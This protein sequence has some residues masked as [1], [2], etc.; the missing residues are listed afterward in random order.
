MLRLRGTEQLRA[1]RTSPPVT[2]N[3]P[4]STHSS[5]GKVRVFLHP[6]TFIIYRLISVFVDFRLVYLFGDHPFPPFVCVCPFHEAPFIFA[7]LPWCS[8][9]SVLGLYRCYCCVFSAVFTI[10][11]LDHVLIEQ[12]AFARDRI[13]HH[14]SV[15]D[16]LFSICEEKQIAEVVGLCGRSVRSTCLRSGRS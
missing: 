12:G 10:R 13:S 6:S 16:G 3:S 2:D 5:G 8:L 11:S 15:F 9:S 4:N 1:Q 14:A 7:S